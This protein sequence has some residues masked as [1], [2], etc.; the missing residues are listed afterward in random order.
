[1]SGKAE[2]FPG[3]DPKYIIEALRD[4]LR[5][6]D[7]KNQTQAHCLAARAEIIERQ[8]RM[9]GRAIAEIQ[10]LTGHC[11]ID[12][13][14]CTAEEMPCRGICPLDND[15]EI[16]GACWRRWLEQAAQHD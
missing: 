7:E 2:L 3:G 1:M 4:R 15:D 12:S 9:I 10:N 8:E 5:E 11:P 6:L 14:C 16:A 13:C